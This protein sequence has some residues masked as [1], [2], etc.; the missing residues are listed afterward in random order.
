MSFVDPLREESHDSLWTSQ[1]FPQ[2]G[3]GSRLSARL[4]NFVVVQLSNLFNISEHQ[5]IKVYSE[6]N[7]TYL[8]GSP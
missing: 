7:L 5:F 2:R 6:G 4:C 3:C 8:I 1:E